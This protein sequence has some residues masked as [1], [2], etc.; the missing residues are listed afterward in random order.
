[1]KEAVVRVLL[2]LKMHKF[3]AWTLIGVVILLLAGGVVLLWM[4]PQE[5]TIPMSALA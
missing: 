1:M 4:Q 2:Y 5:K 3:A